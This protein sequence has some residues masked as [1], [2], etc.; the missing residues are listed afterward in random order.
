MDRKEL[1]MREILLRG[2]MGKDP[3]DIIPEQEARGQRE[4]VNSTTLP[5]K[6][7]HLCKQIE[8]MGIVFGEGVDDLF[9]QVTLPEGWKK[10]PTDHSMWSR[11]VDNEG[12]ER[13][14]I[15]YKAAFYDRDA[16]LSITDIGE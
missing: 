10:E 2:M 12:R 6:P 4:F 5:K 7:S 8:E 3:S 14:K 16:F 1:D 13:A 11:L 9:I 15:F